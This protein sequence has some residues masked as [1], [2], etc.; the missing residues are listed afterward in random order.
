MMGTRWP[1][2]EYEQY[3]NAPYRARGDDMKGRAIATDNGQRLALTIY[4]EEPTPV[5]SADAGDACCIEI[6]WRQAIHLAEDLLSVA[7]RAM[8]REERLPTGQLPL[9]DEHRR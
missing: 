2:E 9:G 1:K 6:T 5:G 3:A 8:A 4:P 7:G